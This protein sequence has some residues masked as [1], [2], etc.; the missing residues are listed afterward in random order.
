MATIDGKSR[1]FDRLFGSVKSAV[2]R[3][4][5]APSPAAQAK[6]LQS[7][8]H[9]ST[10]SF[11]TERDTAN[12]YLTLKP[13][14]AQQGRN[15][16]LSPQ[17]SISDGFGPHPAPSASLAFAPPVGGA[18]SKPLSRSNAW[19]GA[20]VGARRRAI[21]SATLRSANSERS[22][23]SG[24]SRESA[25]D[26]DML[27][28]LSPLERLAHM[29]KLQLD[30]ASMAPKAAHPEPSAQSTDVDDWAKFG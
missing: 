9:T 12:P 29:A 20:S 27:Q 6:G 16:G 10:D 5:K 25:F 4:K 23:M 28:Q 18:V 3:G 8:T 1:G 26:P 22:T 19:R 14:D 7:Q 21:S 30:A 17:S 13:L 11:G 2:T 24:A 15:R